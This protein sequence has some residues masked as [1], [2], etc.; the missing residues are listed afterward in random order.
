TLLDRISIPTLPRDREKALP[1][2]FASKGFARTREG[3]E[4][5]LVLCVLDDRP[6]GAAG[7]SPQQIAEAEEDQDRTNRS[8]A[9]DDVVDGGHEVVGTVANSSRETPAVLLLN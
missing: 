1:G 9:G 8:E 3:Q 6:A 5:G 7:A 2:C 4:C